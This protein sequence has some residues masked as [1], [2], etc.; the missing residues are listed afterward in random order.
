M[1]SARRREHQDCARSPSALQ[2]PFS[3]KGT[4]FSEVPRKPQLFK[5]TKPSVSNA[6]R[7]IQVNFEVKDPETHLKT[8]D[9]SELDSH[10]A[11]I[12]SSL[13]TTVSRGTADTLV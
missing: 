10:Q 13:K 8:R 2:F 3:P 12:T 6:Q 7:A 4:V 11:I 5:S 1:A 9:L